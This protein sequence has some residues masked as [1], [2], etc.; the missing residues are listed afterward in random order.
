MKKRVR[1]SSI[2]AL[3]I[4]MLASIV[5]FSFTKVMQKAYASD[6]DW[7]SEGVFEM[8]DGVSLKLSNSNGLRFIVKM[9][10]D[11]A[12]FVKEN[13]NVEYGFVIAPE[14]LMKAANGDYLNMP[15]KVH[16]VG[17]KQKI[18]Y[19]D[20][21]DF[22]FANGCLTHIQLKN[23][24]YQF[25]AVAYIKYNDVVRYADYN[26]LARNSLYDTVNSAFVDGYA[27]EILSLK[28]YCGDINSSI[29]S[30]KLGWFGTETFPIKVD[31][32]ADYDAVVNVVNSGIDLSQRVVRVEERATP[33]YGFTDEAKKPVII[34]KAFDD[35]V[36]TIDGLPSSVAMPDAIGMIARIKDAEKQFNSLTEGEKADLGSDRVQ[37]LQALLE[38]IEGYDRVYKNDADD[39]TVIPSY[40][41][42]GYSSTV[43]G[44]AST[45][46]DDVYGNVLTVTSNEGGRAA[47]S[48]TNFPDVSKYDKVYFYVKAIGFSA[49][50]YLSDGT[51]NDGW[52]QNW[53]NTWSTSGYWCNANNF[54][55][56]EIDV[57][58]DGYIGKDFALG[59]RTNNTDISFEISDFYGYVSATPEETSLSFGIQVDTGTTN[60]NGKV[61]NISREQWYVDNNNVNTIG[62]LQ[63]SK[64]ANA[65]P[66]GYEHFYFWMYNGTGME[67]N[68]HLAG[69]VSGA[70][71]DSK[72]SIPLKV[73]EWTKVV[74][75]SEDIE[76]NKNGQWY[77]YI[78]GGDG[79]GAS[80]DGWKISSIYAG[81]FA[82]HVFSD[83]ADV[84]D[85]IRLINS[86]P[87]SVTLNDKDLVQSATQAYE[88]LIDEQKA[89]VTNYSDLQNAE[90]AIENYEKALEVVALID[91][92]NPRDIDEAIVKEARIAY[93]KLSRDAKNLVTNIDKLKQYEAEIKASSAL[94]NSVNKL[95]DL[96]A[97]LPDSVVMPDHLVFVPRIEEARDLYAELSDEGKEMITDYAK[98][99]SLLSNIKGY[100]TVYRQTT[101]GVSVIPSYVPGGYSHTVGGSA[102]IASD[103]Y[104]GNYLKVTASSGGRPAIQFNSFPDVSTYSKLF[105][106]IRVVGASCDIYLS[107]GTTNDGWGDGWHNTWS[108]SGLWANNGNWIQKEI[109][110]STGIFTHN[111]ALGLRTS[112]T[113]VSFEITDIVGWAPELGTNTGLTFGNFNATGTLNEYG[114]VYNFTQGWSSDTDMGAFNTN[115]LKNALANGHDS[116]HFWIYN[117][118][119]TDV[120]FGFSGDMNGWNPT[121]EHATSLKAK[122]WT[123]VVITPTIIS[124]GNQG[125]WFVNVTT[126][127]GASGWQIS[128]IYSYNSV[129]VSDDKV[130][131]VQSRIN[132]LDPSTVANNKGQFES[133]REAYYALSEAEKALVDATK[134]FACEEVF[135][136]VNDMTFISGGATQYEVFRDATD[137]YTSS[138]ISEASAFLVEQIQ[139]A[140]GVALKV[141]YTKP[142]VI[143]KYRYAIVL[144]HVDLYND[145]NAGEIPTKEKLGHAGYI[146]KQVGRTVFILAYDQDGYRMGVLAFLKQVIGYDMIS[147]DCV[148]YGRSAET[149][150][151]LDIVEKPSFEYRQQSNYMTNDEIYGMGL[152]AHSDIWIHD[153]A[154]WDMHNVL[155]Y[156]PV[157]KYGSE[158][159]NWYTSDKTQICPTAGGTASEFEDMVNAISSAMLERINLFPNLQN[160]NLSIDDS[161][162][163]D[164]CTCARCKLYNTVYGEAGF[165]AAW[166]DLIN[167]VNKK[168]QAGVGERDI[169]VSFLA[170]RSTEKAPAND[171]FSLL[172]RYQFNDNG[173]YTQTDEYLKCDENVAVWVAPI[174][175]LYAENFNHN[176]NAK[177]LATVKKWL[178]L[179]DR[180]YVWLYGANF[181]YSMYPYNNWQALAE[182]YKIL[183]DLGVKGVWSQSYDKT[184][185]TAF[186]D[187]KTYIESQFAVNANANYQNVLNNYFA[188]YFLD[189]AEPMREMFDAIVNKCE[190]IESGNSGLGRGIYDEIENKAGTL[191]FGKKTYWSKDWINGLVDLCNEAYSAIEKYQ[192]TNP[193][194][195]QKLYD[196]ITK[197]SLFPRYVLCTSFA[198]SYTSSNRKAMRQAFKTDAERLGL[199]QYRESDGLLSG[200]YSNWGI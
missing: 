200:L 46:Q 43:G 148:V 147:E 175:A 69:D 40:I 94:Q 84:K 142:A 161:V 77:V 18:Y 60:E 59:F 9:D 138:A 104:Y 63:Q 121:G 21:K 52:G 118:Q 71:T 42:G 154:G 29:E 132:E 36:K 143:N 106:N 39:G 102:S 10:D 37:K 171:D 97:S 178:A 56:I 92:I 194:L 170:Y 14:Q 173:T 30:E 133:T 181:K 159:P 105:F 96:I 107:D 61:Y 155:N 182:N 33:S 78:L 126:G 167:A 32:T 193:E 187:L 5:G 185:F 125:T 31:T 196:R 66:Q 127:A 111:W 22:Y 191:G 120:V 3:F 103:S 140:T 177:H 64:L 116:L 199:T 190:E 48:F 192:T 137:D 188:N 165:S 76:L 73:N 198:S 112:N 113:N 146:I 100:T 28:T 169:Y 160:I 158:H 130:S 189:A 114:D 55:L 119:D 156:L 35:M 50:I 49:D 58:N 15:K 186:T 153:V 62:T 179:S 197:E 117:P 65:L 70:W 176:V 85:V 180:V 57:E 24:E 75:S 139:N 108:I 144:G 109:A 135:F 2:V 149:L 91:S 98:L 27:Q 99:R 45:R 47:L 82:P 110:V 136:D 11:V 19:E 195:Y 152:Q 23:F 134:L 168:I 51:S 183:S 95:N 6:F 166:I 115:A 86:L 129:S 123:E 141:K 8:E 67:Y 162:G 81:P 164:A 38:A 20:G 68:F 89:Q 4:C 79:A 128:P 145:L 44:S 174:D 74:I 172:K 88:A 157:S 25:V 90:K 13:E 93:T 80:K 41:P 54:R 17:N 150:P 83:Y 1:I 53:K 12:S 184:E 72:D 7:Q 16:V 163:G 26:D 101:S 151:V 131:A 124:E 34:S 122:A 87:A